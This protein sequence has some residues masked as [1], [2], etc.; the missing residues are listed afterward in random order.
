MVKTFSSWDAFASLHNLTPHQLH[1]FQRYY[2]LLSFYSNQINLTTLKS[3]DEVIPH[4]FN[5]SLALAKACA[6][7]AKFTLV[8]VGTGA[9]FPGVPLSILYPESTIILLEVTLKKVHFLERVAQ[10]LGLNYQVLPI[11]WRT[12]L[13]TTV[14]DVD[15]V[16]ARASLQPEELV[17]MFKP[18]CIYAKSTLVYWAS[19]KWQSP[20]VVKPFIKKEFNYTTGD[21]PRRLIFCANTPSQPGFCL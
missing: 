7:P 6:L 17:R 16:C 9:G 1:Q 4:H 12:F 8:D 19:T 13:R 14:F 10:E 5:D 3:L 21:I 2:D 15:V 20:D 18:S 11:D